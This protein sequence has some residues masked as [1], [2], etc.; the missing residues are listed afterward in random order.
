MESYQ[1]KLDKLTEVYLLIEDSEID[2]AFEK[3]IEIVGRNSEIYRDVIILAK[4]NYSEFKKGD[5]AD[6]II[7]K[8]SVRN[9]IIRRLIDIITIVEEDIKSK[10]SNLVNQQSLYTIHE[11]LFDLNFDK[12]TIYFQRSIKESKGQLIS[13][14]IRA[15][16]GYGQRWLY[17]RFI[18]QHSGRHAPINID[19]GKMNLDLEGFI[20]TLGNKLVEDYD[21]GEDLNTRKIQLKQSLCFKVATN[22][23]FIVIE[24]ASN[25]IHSSGFLDFY[26]MLSEFN[27]EITIN[28][29][30]N[31]NC[32]FFFVENQSTPY[33][34]EHYLCSS[35][36]EP[37]D[38]IKYKDFKIF[39]L[40]E[41]EPLDEECIVNWLES[42]DETIKAYLGDCRSLIEEFDGHPMKTIDFLCQKIN[43][44]YYYIC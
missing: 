4:N 44:Y 43:K 20:N 35:Q 34:C 41:I 2:K 28:K 12:Q 10:S 7:D 8:N 3:L 40:P 42:K 22:T 31:H 23:Q 15:N 5:L 18:R 1:D 9:G 26:Q 27:L 14:L 25:F 32:V 19:M 17:N 38:F 36:S 29:N 21:R 16:P 13:F 24:N 6:T 39:G 11:L 33:T 37:E 30:L